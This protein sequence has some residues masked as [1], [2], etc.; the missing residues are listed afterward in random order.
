MEADMLLFIQEHLRHPAL[1]PVVKAI[2]SLGDM[3]MFWIILTLVLLCFQKTRTAGLC[4]MIAM[5]LAYTVNNLILKN[6]IARIRPY[7][8]IDGLKLLVAKEKDFS[9]PSGHTG[10]S[11][12]S[13]VGMYR[14]LPK[15]AAVA[16]IILAVLIA[17]SRLYVGVHYPTDVLGGAV[18]GTTFGLTGS[19]L[20]RKLSDKFQKRQAE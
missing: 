11:F 3:G 16:L 17:L 14:S 8:V 5:I 6:V 12:A 13:S 1:T 9:F 20:G 4:S 2:T 7:E 15:K 19:Y 18:L 10:M